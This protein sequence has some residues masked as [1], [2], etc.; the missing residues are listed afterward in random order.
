MW[1]ICLLPMMDTWSRDL[2]STFE[3]GNCLLM[4]LK[5]TTNAYPDKYRYNNFG[6]G[7]D[8][9]SQFSL[10]NGEFS[11]YLIFSIYNRFINAR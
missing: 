5:L 9:L 6:I 3:V 8:V 7:F 10:P 1:Q 11:K 4:I 2:R